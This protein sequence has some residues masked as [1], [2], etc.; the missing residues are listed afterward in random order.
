[1]LKTPPQQERRLLDLRIPGT[2]SLVILKMVTLATLLAT[3][4]TLQAE[5]RDRLH[6][7][8]QEWVVHLDKA[9]P[10]RIPQ[11]NAHQ[12]RKDM[13][14][15]HLVVLDTQDKDKDKEDT[16]DREDLL[17]HGEDNMTKILVHQRL[18][19]TCTTEDGVVV[20][21]HLGLDIH[22]E[23]HQQ[24]HQELHHHHPLILQPLNLLINI[25]KVEWALETGHNLGAPRAQ[26]H[27]DPQVECCHKVPG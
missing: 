27:R 5:I 6:R 7:T 10:L 12:D 25:R 21:I 15:V 11:H 9:I 1:M 23:V 24:Q 22:K 19:M 20:D 2:L 14:A 16:Q 13:A 3:T 26:V 18:A 8:I 4:T 17:H